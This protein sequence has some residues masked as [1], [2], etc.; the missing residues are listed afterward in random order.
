MAWKVIL[1]YLY[2]NELNIYLDLYVLKYPWNHESDERRAP[3]TV[4]A[5]NMAQVFI[6]IR[7]ALQT[8]SFA[9]VV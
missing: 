5:Y 2:I 1:P 8:K 7:H 3:H 4:T 6:N 9:L